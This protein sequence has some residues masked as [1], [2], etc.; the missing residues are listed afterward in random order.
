VKIKRFETKLILKKETISHL[1]YQ[2]MA[3]V[4]GGDPVSL[5]APCTTL[6]ETCRGSICSFTF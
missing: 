2:E 6:Y 4:K 1:D 5:E 3:I